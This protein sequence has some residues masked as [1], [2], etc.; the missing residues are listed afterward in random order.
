MT[1]ETNKFLCTFSARVELLLLSNNK[2]KLYC[3]SY[4]LSFKTFAV[5][6][7]PVLNLLS[8]RQLSYIKAENKLQLFQ[9]KGT[10]A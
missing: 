4:S 10:V 8:S 6:L 5:R 2:A 3:Y 9:N 1:D 7:K